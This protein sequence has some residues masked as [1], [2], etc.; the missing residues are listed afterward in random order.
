MYRT[1]PVA[2]RQVVTPANCRHSKRTF[3]QMF[4]FV[5][6]RRD[7]TADAKLIHAYLVTLHRIGKD[8]TQR[9][10]ADALGTTRHK[11][12]SGLQELIDAGLVQPIRYGLGRPNGY[13]LLGLDDDDLDGTCSFRPDGSKPSG[14]GGNLTRARTFP[15]KRKGGGKKSPSFADTS[16]L[17]ESREGLYDPVT[18]R[19]IPSS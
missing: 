7:L 16:G 10:I 19:M 2:A 8:L 17:I 18:R 13:V 9:E 6:Q 1:S 15:Q 4:E 5:Y 11:V 14:R 3:A 12:W